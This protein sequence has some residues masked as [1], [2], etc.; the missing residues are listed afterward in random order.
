[1]VEDLRKDGNNLFSNTSLL[2]RQ[3]SLYFRA[4]QVLFTQFFAVI[5]ANSLIELRR[6]LWLKIYSR[7]VMADHSPGSNLTHI[8]LRGLMSS[9]PTS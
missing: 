8:K 3:L 1:M 9:A 6:A 2:S 5:F 7:L 4:I